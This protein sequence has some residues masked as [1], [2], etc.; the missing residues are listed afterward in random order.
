MML[1]VLVSF[2]ELVKR[3]VRLVRRE[4]MSEVRV[5]PFLS[6]RRQ[7]CIFSIFFGGKWESLHAVWSIYILFN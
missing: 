2:K 3:L 5:I 6:N 7:S 4:R 1:F